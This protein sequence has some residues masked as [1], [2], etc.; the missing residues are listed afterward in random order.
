[1]NRFR[2][3]VTV[4]Y[5]QSAD[6]RIAT[7]AG[8][9]QWIS[10]KE[11]LN[12]AHTLRRDNQAILAGIGTVLK[13]DPLLTCRL[14]EDCRSPVRVV[15]DSALRIPRDSKIVKS[16]R[17]HRTILFCLDTADN[18]RIQELASLGMEV[19]PVEPDSRGQVSLP[20]LLE[21]LFGQGLESLYVEGGSGIIT[22]FFRERLVDRL[23]VVSAPLI[24]GEG[25]PAVGNLNTADL[26]L[27]LRGRTK[28]VRQEGE[29]I[30]WEISFDTPKP[31]RKELDVRALYFT[32]PGKVEIKR[33]TLKANP[34]E[35]LVHSRVMGISHGSES[36][37]YRGTFPRGKSFDGLA[38][39]D[40]Q[41]EYPLKYG[42]M[43]AGV[44]EKGEK[45]FAFFPHQERFFYPEKALIRF[46][47]TAE[48]EDIT[49]YPSVETAYNIVLDT[50]PLPGERI[51]IVGQGMIG[52]LTAEILT[53][54]AGLKTAALEPDTFRQKFSRG[55]GIPCLSPVGLEGEA[56]AH[57]VK[58]I[59]GGFLPDTVIHV[60]GTAEG[61]QNAVDCAAFEGKIIEGSWYGNLPVSISLG[62]KFH[63]SRLTLKSSQVSSV[64]GPLLPRWN[65]ERRTE[66]VKLW[67]EKIKPAKYITH[68]YNL[69]RGQEAF[70]DIQSRREGLLQAVLLP[71]TGDDANHGA[72]KK[73]KK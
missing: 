65:R 37:I 52:L 4:S 44:T 72:Q 3:V 68:R 56:L 18:T 6:G 2:P 26:A 66:E 13:D 60:S 14:P 8:Q 34:G 62:A 24:L 11:T 61:L 10:G 48:F 22:S 29:D 58:K 53:G 57:E 47:D 64:P 59:F 27:A 25:I 46:P 51:L 33:E 50:A 23:F 20:G 40:G 12:F 9:S 30:V 32:S 7:L 49:L 55:L 19:V 54:I 31:P 71:D 21:Y 28:S 70:R 1:M 38:S 36:R 5:A 15:V 17:E 42:Y 16:A 63:R 69:D 45:V 43:N 35:V 39:L 67:L 41:M 73:E